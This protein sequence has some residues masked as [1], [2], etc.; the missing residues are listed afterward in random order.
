MKGDGMTDKRNP[1]LFDG[2]GNVY[3]TDITLRDLFAAFCAGGL[4][5]KLGDDRGSER[6]NAEAAY[7]FAEALLDQ[8]KHREGAET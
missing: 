8:R 7:A 6:T 4:M 3:W 5:A 2:D 1:D